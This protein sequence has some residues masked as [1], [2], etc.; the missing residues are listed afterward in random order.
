MPKIKMKRGSSSIDMTAMTDVAFLLLTFF[1]LTAKFR[2]AEPV[3]VDLPASRSELKL[4]E[5]NVLILSIA[6]DGR[7]FFH[8]DNQKVRVNTLLEMGKLY[9]VTFTDGQIQEF[10]LMESFGVPIA[11]LPSLL[12]KTPDERNAIVQSGI[13]MDTTDSKRNE[14]SD[15]VHLARVSDLQ[16]SSSGEI[17]SKGIRIAIRGDGFVEYPYIEK[18]IETLQDRKINKFNLIT[19]LKGAAGIGGANPGAE[20]EADE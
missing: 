15:W 9:N 12:D 3:A 4:P 17:E 16:L 5:S 20:E 7:V 10:S 1:M 13:P 11:Q 6:K 14:L 2:A 19:T 18:V 8:V